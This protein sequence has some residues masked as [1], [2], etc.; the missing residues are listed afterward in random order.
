VTL[1]DKE[2]TANLFTMTPFYYKTT[3]AGRNRL[4][5]VDSLQVTVDTDLRVYKRK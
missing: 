4:Y 5:G 1:P 3:E 2:A